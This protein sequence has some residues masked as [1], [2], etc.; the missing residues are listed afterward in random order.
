MGTLFPC[1]GFVKYLAM[2]IGVHEP[3]EFFGFFMLAYL[4]II[5]EML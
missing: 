4:F 5:Y 3:F 2:N 1:L